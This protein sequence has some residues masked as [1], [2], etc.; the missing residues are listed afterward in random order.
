MNKIKFAIAV[1]VLSISASAQAM[2]AQV[3]ARWYS[4]MFFRLGVV[5]DNGGFCGA[6]S[7]SWICW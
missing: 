5:A 7:D 3:P 6:Q 4:N 1:A 2:P